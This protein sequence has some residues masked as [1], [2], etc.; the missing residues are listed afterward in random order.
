MA[1]RLRW[2]DGLA[3]ADIYIPTDPSLQVLAEAYEAGDLHYYL[4]TRVNGDQQPH[5]YCAKGA[6]K[7]LQLKLTIVSLRSVTD[8]TATTSEHEEPPWVLT[9]IRDCYSLLR[10]LARFV[11]DDAEIGI[12]LWELERAW[13]VLTKDFGPYLA[14]EA[15]R[16]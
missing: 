9:G 11:K 12:C 3:A 15:V 10:A 14:R 7:R 1:R 16:R 8:Y 5:M 4:E 2:G 13:P 6:W